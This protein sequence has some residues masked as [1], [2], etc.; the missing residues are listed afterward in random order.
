MA[1]QMALTHDIRCLCGLSTCTS[2]PEPL[3]QNSLNINMSLRLIFINDLIH[4]NNNNSVLNC[5]YGLNYK[6]LSLKSP[7]PDGHKLLILLQCNAGPSSSKRFTPNK[8][9]ISSRQ[10]LLVMSKC[11]ELHWR[12]GC[13]VANRCVRKKVNMCALR[14]IK[15]GVEGWG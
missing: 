5:E 10:R 1:R 6:L 3:R 4:H 9:N 7:W 15:M 2:F 13:L 12:L 11:Q 14:M 8:R